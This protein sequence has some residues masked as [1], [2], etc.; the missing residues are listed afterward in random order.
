MFAIASLI[1][2][3]RLS[4]QVM[5]V[6][7]LQKGYGLIILHVTIVPW[8]RS[9]DHD[10]ILA[11]APGVAPTETRLVMRPCRRRVAAG[12]FAAHEI[13]NAAVQPLVVRLIHSM[14]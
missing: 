10:L 12:P 3:S 7:V 9:M 11:S 8:K 13:L 6:A 2:G 5:R 1:V 14:S 4:S